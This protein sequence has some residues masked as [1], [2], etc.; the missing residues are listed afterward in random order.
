M[1]L[2]RNYNKIFDGVIREVLVQVIGQENEG[3]HNLGIL[4]EG[5]VKIAWKPELI[6]LTNKENL[7]RGK[8]FSIEISAMQVYDMNVIETI[9][10]KPVNL[11]LIGSTSTTPDGEYIDVIGYIKN[12]V[13]YD[14]GKIE[15]DKE[16]SSIVLKAEKFVK[17]INHFLDKKLADTDKYRKEWEETAADTYTETIDLIAG[18]PRI[19]G[20][21][22]SI[23]SL[24]AGDEIDSVTIS[25]QKTIIQK[26]EVN[27]AGMWQVVSNTQYSVNASANT[28]TLQSN[29][30]GVSFCVGDQIRITF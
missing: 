17:N 26:L 25:L 7:Q 20:S 29:D 12:V 22:P 18:N 9:C 10:N 30:R 28:I 24:G 1:L 23:S 21:S 16:D 14:E 5:A 3:W 4:G 6:K 19:V 13:L 15:S 11:K 27:V 2:R 8:T